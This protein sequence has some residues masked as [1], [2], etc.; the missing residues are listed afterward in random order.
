MIG[1]RGYDRWLLMAAFALIGFGAIMIYSSTAV[2]SPPSGS[3]NMTQFFFF[4]RHMFTVFAGLAAMGIV[5]KVR[6]GFIGRHSALFLLISFFLLV[7]VFTPMGVSAGGARRWL[8]LWPSTFQPSEFV[9]LAMVVFLARYMSRPYFRTD[10]VFYFAVPVFVMLVFQAVFLKQP[11]FGAAMSLGVLTAGMLFLAGVRM[12]YLVSLALSALPVVIFLMYK[13]PYRWKRITSFIDP[14]KDPQGSGFQLVQS[15]IAL[16]SGGLRGVGLGQSRQ[17]LSF[18]PEVHT[19][20]I[21]A[22]VGEELGF[23]V[24]VFVVVGFTVLFIRGAVV[25]GRAKDPFLYYLAYGL[26]LMIALQAVVNFYVIM[27]LLPT[28]GLPLPF[29]SYG[30]SSLLVNMAAVGM[31]L[32]ISRGEDERKT[33]DK[34]GEAMRMKKAKRAV[35]GNS[36]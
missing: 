24:A 30:G 10:S 8:R 20:F 17:K 28:K 2:V 11:D 15:Y 6:P 7:L 27:G 21:F 19:D 13:E 22:I 25:A 31:L 35:Y 26:S 5:M 32:N 34:L 12:R 4:K 29:I 9:K 16:G 23:F 3:R 14:W 18:L 33:T 1:H 36:P